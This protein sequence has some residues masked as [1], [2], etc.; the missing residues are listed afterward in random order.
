MVILQYCSD[1]QESVRKC[2]SKLYRKLYRKLI[3]QIQ[4]CRAE[5]GVLYWKIILQKTDKDL[6]SRK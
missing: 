3:A 5:V 1:K 2:D 6:M 4:V